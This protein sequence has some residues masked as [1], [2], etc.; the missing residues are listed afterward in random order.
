MN[1]QDKRAR[2][3]TNAAVGGAA[4]SLWKISPR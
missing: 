3:I 2:R 4:G 1:Q